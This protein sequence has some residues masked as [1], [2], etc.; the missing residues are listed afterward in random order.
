M[1][2]PILQVKDINV[3]YLNMSQEM[4]AVRNVEFT[5]CKGERMGIIGESGSGKSSLA[6]SIMG[7]LKGSAKVDGQVLYKGIDFNGMKEERIKS[8]RWKDIAMVFQNSEEILNPVLTVGE[9]IEEALKHHTSLDRKER[10]KKAE[11]LMEMVGLSKEN[12]Y[13]YSHELSGGMRQKVLIAMALSC[14]PEILIVDE[15]TTA[16]DAISKKEIIELLK[17][18]HKC[19]SFSMIVISHELPVIM[20]LS[21]KLMVM[22]SGGVVEE[23]STVEIIKSPMHSYTRGLVEASPTVNPFRDLWGIPGEISECTACQCPFYKRC[24]QRTEQCSKECPKLKNVSLGRK[25]ACLRGGI[26]TLLKAKNICKTYMGKK[27][28]VNACSACDLF[29]RSGETVVLI[30]QSGSGKTTLAQT[31]AGIIRPDSGSVEFEERL[32]ELNTETAKKNGIQIV[33]QD[34]LSSTN[35][36]FNIEQVIREPL[37]ILKIESKDQRREMVRK[38]LRDVQLPS[39]DDFLA[40]KV[41]MLSGGQRQRIAIARSLILEPKLLIADEISSMLDPSTQANI[42]RLLKGLQNEKGFALLY[43]THDLALARKIADRAYV[44]YNGKII[45]SG[46]ASEILNTPKENYTKELVKSANF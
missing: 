28:T 30:G 9:Q 18:L 1:G 7:L 17:G 2:K 8:Y 3:E 25:V 24:N 34:P 21:S 29:V 36:L 41:Y 27:I 46:A 35:E 11:N 43:V 45:E 33:F 44:M 5:L 19:K 38:V 16:L 15:P 22:Y 32:I 10:R 40:R 6:M 23:G 42:L 12:I 31:L 14:E 39:S 37:D 4:K 20:S 13:S 26:V